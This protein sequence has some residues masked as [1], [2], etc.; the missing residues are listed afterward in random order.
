MTDPRVGLLGI[1]AGVGLLSAVFLAVIGG[2]VWVL[3]LPIAAVSVM[4]LFNLRRSPLRLPVAVLQA[5]LLGLVSLP[6]MLNGTGVITLIGC[7]AA[8][9]AIFYREPPPEAPMP[10]WLETRRVRRRRLRHVRAPR[11]G[12]PG[13]APP[14]GSASPT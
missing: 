4:V 2:H 3:P 14:P 8:V 10:P 11:P 1:S 7:L 5:T 9:A 12:A 6:L 13:E